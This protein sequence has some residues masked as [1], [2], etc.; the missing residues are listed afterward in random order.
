MKRKLLNSLAG[1]VLA[2]LLG[3]VVM[4][5]QG[6]NPVR[7]Y[8]ALFNYSLGDWYSLTTTLRNSVPLI[9]T[10]LSASIAFASGPVNLG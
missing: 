4:L 2:L 9:L 7:T 5:V 3:A 8:T 1:I 10:G 6:Y